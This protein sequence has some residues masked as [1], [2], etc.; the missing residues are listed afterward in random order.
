[1]ISHSDWDE[2]I[3]ELI[4]DINWNEPVY[5]NCYN[6]T[7]I[8]CENF[9]NK[10]DEY[11]NDKNSTNEDFHNKNSV[12]KNFNSIV[13]NTKKKKSILD[14]I[15]DDIFRVL[16]EEWIPE[17]D[18]LKLMYHNKLLNLKIKI[19]KL[20][21]KQ[22]YIR[23]PNFKNPIFSELKQ[24]KIYGYKHYNEDKDPTEYFITDSHLEPLLKIEYLDIN[25]VFSIVNINYMG[26]LKILKC[27]YS[28][29]N[30]N[31]FNQL[32]Q[33]EEL[34]CNCTD[35]IK[36][37]NYFKKLRI[38]HC[39]C[40][41]MP[42]SAISELENIEELNISWHNDIYDINHLKKLKILICFNNSTFDSNGFNELTELE[43]LYMSEANIYD[44]GH[45]TKLKK[46]ICYNSDE[47]EDD[48]YPENR[49][50]SLLRQCDIL[51]LINLEV[52]IFRDNKFITSLNHMEKLKYL[53]FMYTDLPQEGIMGL[54]NLEHINCINNHN[55]TSL[56]HM[57]KLKNIYIVCKNNLDK[58]GISELIGNEKI[59][60]NRENGVIYEDNFPYYMI[61]E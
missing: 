42:Q 2:D 5:T 44:I 43:E 37:L 15:P 18:K 29:I 38:L 39:R 23:I 36:K 10:K 57:K 58:E 56:N 26:N 19:Y 1:M 41:W 20:D 34:Y 16:M 59:S 35:N 55:I 25:N 13:E 6:S 9:V 33:L 52:F 28:S 49:E 11:Y 47:P 53:T 14:E 24:L 61:I 30:S 7:N 60:Y 3:L 46:L 12:D 22:E 27:S 31:G 32:I 4:R 48:P 50:P 54:E 51:P 40:C 21:L 45:F 17:L 8:F